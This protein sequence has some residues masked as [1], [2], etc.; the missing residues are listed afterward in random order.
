MA[1]YFPR[2]RRGQSSTGYV[3]GCASN[4][5]LM[6][7]IPSPQDRIE[8]CRDHLTEVRNAMVAFEDK[9]KSK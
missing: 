9:N 1:L 8:V 3:A 5:N 2:Y 6:R 4:R 7:V